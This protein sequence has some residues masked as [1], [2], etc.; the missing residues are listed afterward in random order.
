MKKQIVGAAVFVLSL[1][2][3]VQRIMAQDPVT[4]IIKAAAVKVIKGIDLQVQRQQNKVIRLQNAQKTLEN[5]M[6]RQKLGEISGWV[7]KQ[8]DLYENYYADLY[9]VKTT[10]ADFQ[11]IRNIIGKQGQLMTEYQRAWRL[12]QQDQHF[13]PKELGYM[14]QV[15]TGILRESAKNL[16][17]VFLVV[18]PFATQ[19]SD[20]QRLEIL[21]AATTRIETNYQDLKMFNQ[22]NLLL[23]MQRAKAQQDVMAVKKL[24]GLP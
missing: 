2:G 24:Y 5:T 21:Q 14:A 9:R 18:E 12:F 19:M 8:R 20:A 7:G 11:R 6:S 16:D 22:Q 1:I 17:Q 15:Y 23:S 4:A 13:S 10:V 3:P